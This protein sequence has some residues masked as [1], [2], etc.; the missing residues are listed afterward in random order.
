[1]TT[2]PNSSDES[3]RIDFLALHG[4][5]LLDNGY[6]IVPIRQGGKSPD[7]EGWAK[8]KASK[9]Q[10]REWLDGGHRNAGVGILTKYTPAV[11]LDIRDPDVA[12]LMV[13]Y[14]KEKMGGTLMRIGQAP[15]AL[16]FF[17]TDVPFRK[18]RTT[19]REDDWGLKNQI[20]VLGEGQQA[21]AYHRH[22]ETGRPYTWPDYEENPL[23]VRQADL[24]TITQEMIDGLFAYFEEVC[25]GLGWDIK[26][27]ARGSAKAINQDNPFLEDT[28]PVDMPDGEIFNQLMLV[29]GADDYDV[30]SQIGMCLYHQWDGAEIGKQYWH[31]WSE[32]ADNYDREALEDKWNSFSIDGKLRAPI[33]VRSILKWAAEAVERT[34]LEEGNRLRTMF[35]AAHDMA[36]WDKARK[37]TQHAEIDTITRDGLAAIAKERRDAITGIRSSIQTIRK[38]LAFVYIA[39][40]GDKIPGWVRPYVYDISDDRFFDTERK[41][42]ATKQGFDAMH[43]REAMTKKD[44]VDGRSS[45]SDNAS[46]LAL[47]FFRIRA[48][49]GR[50]Y[51]PGQDEIFTNL[52]GTFANSYT[53]K[54]IPALPEHRIPRDVKNVQRVKDH[55][56]HLLPHEHEQRMFID[57]L[58]WVVQNPGK[59]MN[60]AILLQGVEG[61]GKS[62]FGSLMQAVMGISNVTM[63]NAHIFESDFTD[64]TVGQCLSCVEEVRLIKVHNKYEVLNRIKPFVTNDTIEV[65]PKGKPIHNAKNTTSYLLFSNHKDALPL[66]D[67]GRRYLV[68]FS[69]WQRRVEIR[70]FKDAHPRYYTLLYQTF[71]ESPGALRQWLL[72]HQQAANF[73]PTGDAPQTKARKFMIR[74]AKPEFIQ[75]L[76]QVIRE[77]ETLCASEELVDVTALAEVFMARGFD[78]P[79]P[80]TL[81][82]M[83]T[84]DG[85]EELGKV[86]INGTRDSYYSKSPH[87]FRKTSGDDDVTNASLIREY[88]SERSAKIDDDL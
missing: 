42:S 70:A 73:D 26:K 34:R 37:E 67:D 18:R 19:E 87:L 84:R 83:M 51:E 77:D 75:E 49:Q 44:I 74:Q 31:E 36:S 43:D 54:E 21:V 40:K 27:A 25:D 29:P 7:F 62:F 1:V 28:T 5:K 86:M 8:A 39:P 10:L 68:L 56:A 11:D 12:A 78:W 80:K 61:D 33:T 14:V 16:F 4:A 71:I 30:W 3:K 66:D 59:H 60:Y 48:V 72:D 41:Y 64:W 58:S 47:N 35:A 22:P 63:L 50:R 82:T 32:T 23:E 88:L 85:Y 45:P 81:G 17:R 69:Q 24:P 65:H 46:T 55:I 15:K 52:E 57:W 2:R 53:E 6:S 76:D 13:T 9:E 79:A 20:E 38:A